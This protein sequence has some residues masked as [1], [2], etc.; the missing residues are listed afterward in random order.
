MK[1]LTSHKWPCYT[2]VQMEVKE[3][4]C[5]VPVD[6]TPYLLVGTMMIYNIVNIWMEKCKNLQN[7]KMETAYFSSKTIQVVL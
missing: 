3:V 2:Y 1:A 7:E 5:K 6:E 4:Q